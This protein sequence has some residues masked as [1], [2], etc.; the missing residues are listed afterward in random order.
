MDGCLAFGSTNFFAIVEEIPPSLLIN[1]CPILRKSASS[2]LC[3]CNF[4]SIALSAHAATSRAHLSLHSLLSFSRADCSLSE[5]LLLASLNRLL[6]GRL[7]ELLPPVVG[8]TEWILDMASFVVGDAGASISMSVMF[9]IGSVAVP[10]LLAYIIS[11]SSTLR[12]Q[13]C[14]IL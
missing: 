5:V 11:G 7:S 12:P 2:G 6:V 13:L 10:N 9:S 1:S 3:S 4:F 8:G 14:L